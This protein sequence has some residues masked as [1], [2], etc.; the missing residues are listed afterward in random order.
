M[1]DPQAGNLATESLVAM[2]GIFPSRGPN[3]LE[4]RGSGAN[5][6]NRIRR[7]LVAFLEAK[8]VEPLKWSRPPSQKHLW[9]ELVRQV[10]L[11]EMD[12][13]FND[14][15]GDPAVPVEYMA[16]VSQARE[17]IKNAWPVYPDNSLGLHTFELAP[18]EYGDVWH[19]VRT[20]NDPETIFDDLD[21]MVLLPV[22]VDAIAQIYPA[23]YREICQL[24]MVQLQ[25][26]AGI[27][28]ALQSKTLPGEREEQIRTLL[29]VPND[30]PIN[31][32]P[33]QA[34]QQQPK[35]GGGG[36]DREEI[37]DVNQTPSEH[38]AQ[39]RLMSR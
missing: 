13:W 8:K 10:S 3:E 6:L 22:Q 32:Q 31:A 27:D 28:G 16:V 24:T 37:T 5:Y 4:I 29:R 36:P 12:D 7:R 38:V 17:F 1:F 23:L 18:D 26:Y 30:G 34:P 39:R 21:S 19:L 2:T 15:A 11:D 35:G 25:P 9:S 33:E 20:L 14:W